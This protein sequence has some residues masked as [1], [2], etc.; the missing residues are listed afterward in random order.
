MRLRKMLVVFQFGLSFCFIVLLIVFGRQYRYTLNF[1][2]GFNTGN[3]LDVQLQG[4]D[5]VI[6]K[7]EFSRLAD[8]RELSMSS[9][10]LGM[11]YSSTQVREQAGG[12][13]LKVDQLFVDPDYVG[14]MGLQL[15]AGRNFTQAATPGE[16]HILVNEE[17]LRAW[18]IASPIDAVGRTF[19]V[20]GKPLVVAGVLKN[21]H[22]APLEQPIRSFFLRTDPSQYR[23]ANVKVASADMV[24]T[25]ASMEGVWHKLSDSRKLEAHFFDDEMEALYHFYWALL[26]MVGYLGVLAVSISLLGL[27]GMVIYT[28]ETRLREVGIRKVFGATESS[29]TVLLSRDFIR[30][31]LWAVGF[32]IP[33]SFFL[34]DEL[35]STMQY[36]RVHLNAWDI[37][38]GLAVFFVMGVLTIASQTRRAAGANP[39]DTLRYE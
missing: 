3:I 31:M 12:D 30:L 37:I 26:K 25:M 22:Y 35:L 39:V 20:E 4:V 21:F 14:N 18:Q 32:A 29:L 17:F 16:Q 1:D 34:F 9:G 28:T 5:P 38:L 8:V 27:L 2:Y 36:Y 6:F 11:S 33:V 23:Y 13:S 7:T 15:L 24:A 10:I 19:V